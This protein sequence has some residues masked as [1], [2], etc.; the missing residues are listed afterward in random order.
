M[1]MAIRTL[2]IQPEISEPGRSKYYSPS[3]QE[4]LLAWVYEAYA[5]LYGRARDGASMESFGAM[6]MVG[7]DG[8]LAT[9]IPQS[10]VKNR[11]GIGNS[12]TVS[13]ACQL[14][15]VRVMIDRR[16]VEELQKGLDLAGYVGERKVPDYRPRPGELPNVRFNSPRHGN[17]WVREDAIPGFAQYLRSQTH[18]RPVEWQ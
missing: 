11:L 12:M 2:H 7:L 13:L 16:A 18:G 9:Y 5:I 15:W 4:L 10:L 1:R 6:Q 3:Q 17:V 8:E 14:W